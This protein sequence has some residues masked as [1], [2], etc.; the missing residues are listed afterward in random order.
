MWSHNSQMPSRWVTTTR[1]VPSGCSAASSATARTKPLRF[2]NNSFERRGSPMGGQHASFAVQF[3]II[4]SEGR[5]QM[6]SPVTPQVCAAAQQFSAYTGVTLGARSCSATAAAVDMA[7]AAG[8]LQ[9]T[10]GG[11]LDPKHCSRMPCNFLPTTVPCL[12]PSSVRGA[13]CIV[14]GVRIRRHC[15][16]SASS[17]RSPWRMTTT[18]HDM[19]GVGGSSGRKRPKRSLEPQQLEPVQ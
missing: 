15:C 12:Q 5:P 3:A 17:I 11:R 4:S 7:R 8:L 2:R 16:R 18:W 6:P 1:T 10:S 14:R 19:A 13:S 9:T